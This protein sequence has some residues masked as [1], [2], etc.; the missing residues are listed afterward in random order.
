MNK[1]E[2]VKMDWKTTVT[3]IVAGIAMI[4][5]AF[6]VAVPEFIL[7]IVIGVAVLLL[8]YFAKDRVKA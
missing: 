2:G 7:E 6:G 4:L 5:K 1:G 8:G 3:G